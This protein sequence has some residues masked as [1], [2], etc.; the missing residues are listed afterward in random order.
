MKPL[1]PVVL[2]LALAS[3]AWL[4]SVSAQAAAEVC[5]SETNQ[6]ISGRFRQY[7]E[8]N[9]GLPVFG[10]PITPA[11]HE[12][13]RDIGQTYLTQWFERNRFELHPEHAAPYDVQL[14][15]L[16]DDRLRQRVIDWQSLPRA[17]G[18]PAGCLW[19]A[20]T[21]HSVCDQAPGQSFKSYWTG[22]GLQHSA[23]DAFGRSLALFG[24]PLTE[25]RQELNA[26]GHTVLTQ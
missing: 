13:N 7:W 22:H 20:Q 3:A 12:F 24:L 18:S 23:L 19:F 6:C 15:R 11:W 1:L 14:G 17:S 2:M 25:P 21:G 10:Y 16:G 5:F 8:Q 26:S 9:G 4:P